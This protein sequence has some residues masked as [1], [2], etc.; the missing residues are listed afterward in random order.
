MSD[1]S[2]YLDIVQ[3]ERAAATL[4]ALSLLLSLR[5]GFFL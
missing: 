2:A 3:Q 5:G 1:G 4:A